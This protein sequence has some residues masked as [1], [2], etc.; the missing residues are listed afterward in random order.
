MEKNEI[1]SRLSPHLFWDVKVEQ[2]DI[3]ENRGFI[4]K[5]VLEYGLWED[6][7]VLKN[8]YGLATISEVSQRFRE[9][10]PKSLAFISNLSGVPKEKFR[11]YITKQSSPKHWNF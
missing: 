3:D 6:W 10:D 9:L 8:I 11:C 5:R 4:I 7:L 2:L 1:L